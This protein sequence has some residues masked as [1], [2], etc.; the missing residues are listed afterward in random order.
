M[1]LRL[2]RFGLRAALGFQ[3]MMRGVF[4]AALLCGAVPVA[5]KDGA[6]LSLPDPAEVNL[7]SIHFPTDEK[8]LKDGYK[9]FVFHHNDLTYEEAGRDFAECRV[10]LARGDPRNLPSFVAWVDP[11]QR[12][13][14]PRPSPYG[15][16]GG[17][18]LSIVGPKME[19]GL[20]NSKML[21]CMNPRGYDRYA[22]DE[23]SYDALHEGDER[24]VIAMQAKLASGPAPAVG[25]L[26]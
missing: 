24:A 10:H 7:P 13:L 18:I 16:V 1:Q 9:F 14:N 21:M 26:P 4:F 22:V 12:E 6:D 15:L 23:A 11:Q 3:E 8:S 2:N 20:A 19:R 17:I 25:R 5:A